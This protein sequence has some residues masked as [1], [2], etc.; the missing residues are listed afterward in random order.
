M[1]VLEIDD[2]S[3]GYGRRTVLAGVR[4]TLAAGEGLALVGSNGAGKTTL[5]QCVLDLIAPRGGSI[6]LFGQPSRR[7]VA[8]RAVAYL[9]ENF[10]PPHDLSGREFLRYTQGLRGLSCDEARVRVLGAELGLPTEAVDCPVRKLSK[11]TGQK[12]GLLACLAAEPALYVLDEPMSGLDPEARLLLKRALRARLAAGAALL[13]STHD[14]G[15]VERLASRLA[16][17]D[18]GGLRFLGDVGEFCARYGADDLEQA[19]LAAIAAPAGV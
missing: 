8:R 1:P 5:L 7:P 17:V 9:P 6:R 16:L 3:V 19:Y 18:G 15:D 13:F 12:L 2:L 4:L 14:L 11:G 10:L